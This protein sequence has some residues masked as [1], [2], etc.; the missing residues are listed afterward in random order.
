MQ[1]PWDQTGFER[2]RPDFVNWELCSSG[3]IAEDETVGGNSL[4]RSELKH[5][6]AP[7]LFAVTGSA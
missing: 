7:A 6:A 2:Y 5:G 1:S 3:T 4:L